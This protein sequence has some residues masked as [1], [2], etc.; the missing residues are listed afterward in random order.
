MPRLTIAL[1]GK[2]ADLPDTIVPRLQ[3]LTDRT[4]DTQKTALT[5]LDWLALHLKELA[6]ADD[7]TAAVAALQ[8]Q[9]E[10]DAQAALDAGVKAARDQLLATLEA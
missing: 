5:V 2:T 6:V 10:A 1:D 8:Q 3:R 4:N 7:L 9:Q